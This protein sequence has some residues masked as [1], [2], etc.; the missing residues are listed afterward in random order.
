MTLMKITRINQIIYVEEGCC[1]FRNL[2]NEYVREET[3]KTFV[4]ETRGRSCCS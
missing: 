1:K 4:I 3:V 2:G